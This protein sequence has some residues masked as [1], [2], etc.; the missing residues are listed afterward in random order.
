MAKAQQL[1]Q[2]AREDLARSG[3]DADDIRRSRFVPVVT[4]VGPSDNYVI[5]YFEPDGKPNC[6][7]RERLF[8]NPDQKYRQP[9]QTSPRVYLSP[10]LAEGWLRVVADPSVT[11]IITEGEKKAACACKHGF[12]TLGLGG[13]YSFLSK[14]KP[15]PDL[16]LAVWKGRTVHIAYDSDL[17]SNPNVHRAR[18]ALATELAGRGA[19]VR[20]VDLPSEDNAKVGLD[21][22]LQAHGA[23]ALRELLAKAE[24]FDDVIGELNRK[25]FGSLVGGRYLIG[26]EVHDPV[27]DRLELALLTER[28]FRLLYA[29]RFIKVGDKAV[30]V[31]D[32]W[33]KS[34]WRREAKG[35][36]FAPEADVPGYYNLWRGFSVA[37]TKGKC[38]RYLEH[39]NENVCGGD[40]K[41]NAYVIGW[42]ADAV[43]RPAT[44]PGTAIALR[45]AQGVGKGVAISEFGKLF[46]R[47]FVRVANPRHLTGHFNAH[48]KDALV[49]FADEAF[50]AG[51]KT[52]EGTL[53]ALITEE[54]RLVEYTG[55]DAFPIRNYT[56]LLV[57]SNHEWVV[58][59]GLEE[60]RFCVIDVGNAHMQDH[61]YFARIAEQMENGGRAALLHYLQQ[62]DLSKVDLRSLPQTAALTETK[63]QSLSSTYAFIF[64][65]LRTGDDGDPN[66]EREEHEI[67][68]KLLHTRYLESAKDAGERRR[69]AET[70]LGMALRKLMPEV[71]ATRR[72][73][74][75]MKKQLRL[76]VFPPLPQ[77]RAAFERAIRAPINW[78]AP[79]VSAPARA[80]PPR[81]ARTSSRRTVD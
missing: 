9:A 5:P 63:L 18:V 48:T 52:A 62:H 39:I 45:G 32:W 65:L 76:Y 59:A 47:H 68:R 80:R 29:N 8:G 24:E 42:M 49:L 43:Q 60:R 11:V 58:P 66:W 30:N 53:K 51:D 78:D 64:D 34:R 36:V 72:W 41:L 75:S 1:S 27:F 23:E 13:V 16:D 73:V 61:A 71:R 33:L 74:T 4:P 28:D 77:C 81:G 20:F 37:A 7:H 54:T 67:A 70:E 50:W 46:G 79:D 35:I 2:R 44:L 6:F 15:I 14:G 38:D 12:P 21:D 10:L 69:A 31:P 22:F 26:M 19:L 25:H 56:R 40:K 55:K 17:A 3:L 57:A